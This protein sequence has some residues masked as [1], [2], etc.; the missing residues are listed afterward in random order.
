VQS[1]LP[2]IYHPT[3]KTFSDVGLDARSLIDVPYFTEEEAK[4]LVV[5]YGGDPEVWSRLAYVAGAFGHPQLV[6]AFV[7]GASARG[8]PPSE[9]REI[10]DRGL[11]SGDIDAEREAARRGLYPRS[12]KTRAICFIALVLQL[13]ILTEP[14]R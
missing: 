10:V 8:W 5:L 6:N 13:G 1:L 11:S 7:A 12:P 4:G 3:A 14:W 9:L 2:L